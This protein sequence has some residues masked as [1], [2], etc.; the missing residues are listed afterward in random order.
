M[1]TS[2]NQEN[3][4]EITSQTN[5]AEVSNET[6]D[7]VSN[8]S[9]LV[10]LD[11]VLQEKTESDEKQ[12]S[13]VVA[14]EKT[15]DDDNTDDGLIEWTQKRSSGSIGNSKPEDGEK[16]INENGDAIIADLQKQ[17]LEKDN[18]IA[19]KE[20]IIESFNMIA[21][22]PI[23][24]TWNAHKER[25]GSDA[26][27]SLFM[28]ELGQIK[29]V[30]QRSEDEKLSMYFK[31]LAVSA[32]VRE[33]DIES[34]IQED[35]D[36]FYSKTLRERQVIIRDAEKHL[37]NFE[38]TSVEGLE[39]S[40]K[41]QVN[42]IVEENTMW[43]RENYNMAQDFVNKVVSK[44]RYNGK[45]ID[46]KWGE[47]IMEAFRESRAVLDPR[48]M[49]L[50][51]PDKDGNQFMFIPETVEMIDAIEFRKEN[52]EFYKKQIR[53]GRSENLNERAEKAENARIKKEL[54]TE[55]GSTKFDREWLDAN[56]SFGIKIPS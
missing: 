1:N 32:G 27:P 51:D 37:S 35:L 25:H 8:D 41:E 53:N 49:V 10:T 26:S 42:K 29:F 54:V 11:S 47:K 19:E 56:K 34:A 52:L 55:N 18:I 28:Q 38:L 5:D 9:E 46:S 2:E 24:K 15:D 14:E 31:D 4:L 43:I 17:L 30:D 50:A 33:D 6:Q 45:P 20:R 16:A 7:K 12:N 39:K 21:D 36:A 3:E 48:Y 23:I 40:Y 22:D 44:G 13:E